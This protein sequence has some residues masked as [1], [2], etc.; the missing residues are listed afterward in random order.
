MSSHPFDKVP[1]INQDF[2]RQHDNE[3]PLEV[4]ALNWEP[5][6]DHEFEEPSEKHLELHHTPGGAL[7]QEVHTQLDRAARIRLEERSYIEMMHELPDEQE[8]NFGERS[9]RFIDD[10]DSKRGNFAKAARFE[11]ERGSDRIHERER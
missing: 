4:D 2:T 6:G 7:E 10:P 3:I 5:V 1:N 8:L 9:S 11:R